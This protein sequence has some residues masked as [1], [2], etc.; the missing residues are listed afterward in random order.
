[1][2]VKLTGEG[3]RAKWAI[4]EMLPH[5]K[6][7]ILNYAQYDVNAE[8]STCTSMTF[9]LVDVFHIIENRFDITFAQN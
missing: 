3:K 4:V 1:M 7:N 6:P 8:T 9:D 5:C 2:W